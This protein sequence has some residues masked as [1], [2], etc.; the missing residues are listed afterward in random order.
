MSLFVQLYPDTPFPSALA[1]LSHSNR[2]CRCQRSHRA[3]HGACSLRKVTGLTP[4]SRVTGE[5]GRRDFLCGLPE[6]QGLGLG[7]EV[8]HQQ[9]VV[10]PKRVQRLT[11][12]DE[13]ARD[14]LG[15]LVDELVEGVIRRDGDEV[16][17][18]RLLVAQ[19]PDAPAGAARALVR[20]S[21][22]VKVLEETMKSVS[23]GSSSRVASANSLLSTLETKR[24]VKPQSL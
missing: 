17:G 2:L 18:Y 13:V 15:P 1:P 6:R 16:P 7:E 21:S 11:E 10:R 14:Q 8:R 4:F 19:R 24:T 12:P 9:I 5:A 3:S 20:V 22:V 23:A